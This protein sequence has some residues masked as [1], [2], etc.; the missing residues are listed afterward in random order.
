LYYGVLWGS[1]L[2][3]GVLGD[4]ILHNGDLWDSILYYGVLWGS[5][6]YYGVCG[7]IVTTAML[8]EREATSPFNLKVV[9]TL[10]ESLDIIQQECPR[11]H[12]D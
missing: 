5:L 1:I 4:S 12:S 8:D 9:R 7:V 11:N 2:Y 6:L 3:N 10:M